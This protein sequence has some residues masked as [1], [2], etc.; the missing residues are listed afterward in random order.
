MILTHSGMTHFLQIGNPVS[1]FPYDEHKCV[2]S[3]GSN[4]SQISNQSLTIVTKCMNTGMGFFYISCFDQNILKP[5]LSPPLQS[6]SRACG[7][8]S[9]ILDKASSTCMVL[10]QTARQKSSQQRSFKIVISLY[11]YLSSYW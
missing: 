6:I 8:Q 1:F 4:F 5:L 7:F 2:Q 10:V 11:I 3:C 9:H